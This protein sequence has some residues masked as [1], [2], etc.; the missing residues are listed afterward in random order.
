MMNFR[1]PDRP[2]E[3]AQ[4]GQRDKKI[5][6]FNLGGKSP[7]LGGADKKVRMSFWLIVLTG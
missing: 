7:N 1:T 3:S 4:D 5:F 2:M 6:T